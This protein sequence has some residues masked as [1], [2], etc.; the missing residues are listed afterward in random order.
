LH[1]AKL[2]FMRPEPVMA[3]LLLS[4]YPKKGL[5][6]FSCPIVEVGVPP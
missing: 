4:D 1:S 6:F 3:C 5:Y 2:V